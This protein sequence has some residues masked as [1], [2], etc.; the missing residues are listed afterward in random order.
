[1]RPY[2]TFTTDHLRF[3]PEREDAKYKRLPRAD[4]VFFVGVKS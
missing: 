2:G 3:L 4:K 1:M